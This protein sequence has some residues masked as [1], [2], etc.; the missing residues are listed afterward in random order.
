MIASDGPQ[1]FADEASGATA[2][3]DREGRY[4]QAR[5]LVPVLAPVTVVHFVLGGIG[6]AAFLMGFLLA[7]GGN[8][9]FKQLAGL[10]SLVIGSVLIVGGL[11]VEAITRLRLDLWHA[12]QAN[13]Q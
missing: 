4:R 3:G 5:P 9:P 6:G 12:R 8:T 7:V 10:I 13:R 1:R 11:I 2:V